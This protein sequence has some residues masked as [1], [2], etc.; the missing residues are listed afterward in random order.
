MTSSVKM[1][2]SLL[3][4]RAVM[5]AA[6]VQFYVFNGRAADRTR[7]PFAAVDAEV[8]LVLPFFAIA[9]DEIPYRRTAVFEAFLENSRDSLM[10]F[11]RFF[12]RD[13]TASA[14]GTDSGPK[15]GFIDVNIA[16][17]GHLGLVEKDR[18]Y[19]PARFL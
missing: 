8:F 18:L 3:A 11:R 10:E 6:A 13:L 12:F 14:Q 1:A 19:R 4:F 5:G 15:K 16:D 2:S 7:C 17:T 9:A